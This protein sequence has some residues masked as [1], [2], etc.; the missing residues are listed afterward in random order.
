MTIL[1]RVA[2]VEALQMARS[3]RF[4]WA[5][6]ALLVLLS[7]AAL[8]AAMRSDARTRAAER[9]T[10]GERERWLGQGNKTPHAAAHHG[11]IV[12]KPAGPLAA[13]DEGVTLYAGS[14]V[15]LEPHDQRLFRFRPAEDLTWLRRLAGLTAALTLQQ[16]VPFLVV[17]LAYG[18]IAGE[19][20]QGTLALLVAS[21][22]R[23][24]DVL[25]GKAL[26]VALPLLCVFI[27]AAPIGAYAVLASAVPEA[28][29]ARIAVLSA[30]Y[31][32]FLA[33]WLLLCLAVSCRAA[34][35]DAALLRLLG[36]W[37]LLTVVAP[38]VAMEAAEAL[39]PGPDP[40][41]FAA[42]IQEDR[43]GMVTWYERLA[44]IERRLLA[45]YGKEQLDDLPVSPQGVG[46]VEEEEDQDRILER[47]FE[48]LL[49]SH[50][51]QARRF[52]WAGLASPVIS[53]QSLSAGLAATHA[54]D[55]V[56]FLRACES[57]RR[58]MVQTLNRD[59]AVNDIPANRTDLGI[60]GVTETYYQP[61][62]EVWETVPAFR[63]QAASL[64]VVVV[65]HR[66]ALLGLLSWAVAAALLLG[67]AAA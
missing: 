8:T 45:Q 52:E 26:G 17:F 23:P 61:G 53:L 5:A 54:V 39:R 2:R 36:L 16:L 56:D 21:G 7:A 41:A 60:P 18:A 67:R 44:A 31:V 27:L 62:R 63:Y 50:E 30:A 33:T 13:F 46:L 55:H 29:G 10:A 1:L 42:G 28:L 38:P 49:A 47:H 11:V 3:G 4:R 65:R 66:A 19:R 24:R 51:G 43:Y 64:P 20:E 6:G 35:S 48:A 59:S 15:H 22:A 9:L 32:T 40:L 37:G 14:V 57:Y 58:T 34:S 25:L 12:A